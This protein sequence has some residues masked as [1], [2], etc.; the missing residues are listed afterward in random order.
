[1]NK[2]QQ[3]RKEVIEKHEALLKYID[4][5]IAVAPLLDDADKLE[6]T[7]LYIENGWT[8]LSVTGDKHKLNAVF[9]ML[10][11]HG[12]QT[13]TR[14]EKG[15]SQYN[16]FFYKGGHSGSVYLSFSST[17]CRRVKVG[18]RT[19]EITEDIYETVCDEQ[20]F[21]APDTKPAAVMEELSL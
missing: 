8:S 11:R 13:A 10:R 16:A 2:L 1:M 9:G 4:S 15:Q 5:Q 21:P 12:W 18:T 6:P 17:Q 7:S 19:K 20:E 14:P 3:L